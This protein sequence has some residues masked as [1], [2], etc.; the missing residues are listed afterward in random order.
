MA[1]RDNLSQALANAV[2]E[3][4]Q[5]PCKYTWPWFVTG[6]APSVFFE[7]ALREARKTLSS[8][9]VLE[10]SDG[11]LRLPRDL[12]YVDPTLFAGLD[13]RPM[14]LSH[15]TQA[16]YLSLEYPTWTIASMVDLGVSRLTKEEFLN[17]LHGMITDDPHGF[18]SRPQ[19]WHEEL[20]RILLPLVDE[21][22]LKKAIK[23]LKIIPLVDGSWTNSTDTSEGAPP[24][25]WPNDVDLHGSE[26]K[27]PFSV[28]RPETLVNVE[29]R[30]LFERLDITKLDRERICNGI[31]AAHARNGP[32]SFSDPATTD[33]L[34]LISHARLL[35]RESWKPKEYQ[36]RELWLASSDGRHYRGSELF[37][38]RHVEEPSKSNGVNSI[39][40]DMS[41][42]LH[43]DYLREMSSYS[44]DSCDSHTVGSREDFVAYMNRTFRVSTVPRLVEWDTNECDFSLSGQFQSLFETYPASDILQ[45]ILDNWSLYSPWIE[46]NESHRICGMCLTST[47]NLLKHICES[48]SHP[49]H[50]S[51]T[52]ILDTVLPDVDP[53]VQDTSLPLAVVKV[54]NCKDMVTRD[55]LGYLGVITR[56]GYAFYLQCL[57]GMKRQPNPSQQD[58]SYVYQQIQTHYADSKAEIEYVYMIGYSDS[59]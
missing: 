33:I 41:P 16:R 46:R 12:I 11:Q 26:A 3:L 39:L 2:V 38:A 1:L 55:R 22:K 21:T 4:R 9:R 54:S 32:G 20:A 37:V 17:D 51:N 10:S 18:H 23:Q 43:R 31:I 52:R 7:P 36:S 59:R 13:G 34:E 25:F 53:F 56:K 15:S 58:V 5:S 24:V 28:V 14:T 48:P 6:A 19:K 47:A 42:K 49:E 50:G 45:L 35:H 30:K 8:L 29:R 57:Y 44:S 40:E 27:L